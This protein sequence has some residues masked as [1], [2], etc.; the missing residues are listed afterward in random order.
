MAKLTGKDRDTYVQNMFDR[1]AGRYNILNR[2]MTFGQDMRWRRYVVEQAGLPASGS[3][4]DLAAG[5]GDIAFEAKHTVPSAH[6][7][8][9]DFSI[10]MMR[11]GQQHEF[12][13]K[14]DW[15]AA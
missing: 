2:L 14:V 11:V 5:T 6:I 4:L 7:V 10:G 12:G 8:A 9:A 13:S 15:S 3:L 1:V